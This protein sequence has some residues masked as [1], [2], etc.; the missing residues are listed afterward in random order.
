MARAGLFPYWNIW[1]GPSAVPG[2]FQLCT[3]LCGVALGV[4]TPSLC[5]RSI[6]GQFCAYP[7][8]NSEVLDKVSQ[9][10]VIFYLPLGGMVSRFTARG[11]NQESF[12][13]VI[14]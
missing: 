1:A 14:S 13:N 11:D 8:R 12:V 5:C 3:Q 7:A 2:N 4:G 9:M 6:S 10:F